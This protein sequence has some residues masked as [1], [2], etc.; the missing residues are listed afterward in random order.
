LKDTEYFIILNLYTNV[1]AFCIISYF[2]GGA[3]K[4]K[5]YACYCCNI[6]H[7]SLLT[8]G[9]KSSC[10]NQTIF[11]ENLM[12]RLSEEHTDLVCQWPHLTQYPYKDSRIWC[13]RE[14]LVTFQSDSRHIEYD[15][16]GV[17]LNARVQYL[18]LLE[19]A[20]H[21][22]RNVQ[23]IGQRSAELQM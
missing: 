20:L 19:K 16:T 22:I 3:M 13:G 10:Y 8:A 7:D 6:H 23:V 21:I 18:Q 4:N 14:G 9:S 11:D 5:N 2:S 1:Y 17:P 12:A 15:Y